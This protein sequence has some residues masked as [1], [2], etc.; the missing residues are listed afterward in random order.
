MYV[1]SS[2]LKNT[3]NLSLLTLK[4]W[5]NM[6]YQQKI[7]RT[8]RQSFIFLHNTEGDNYYE[9]ETWMRGTASCKQPSLKIWNRLLLQKRL[10]LCGCFKRSRSVLLADSAAWT[11]SYGDS[12][13]QSFSTFAG[14]PYFISLEDLIEEGV[15]TKK[16]CDS[17]DFG[18]NKTS[19][20]YA[21]NL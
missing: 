11:T 9:S 15:L 6:T 5:Y 19:I 18:K 4:L 21:K 20:D 8:V 3:E 13:Y 12:P 7:T 2:Y 17:A 16:E 1:S 10:W 14:N